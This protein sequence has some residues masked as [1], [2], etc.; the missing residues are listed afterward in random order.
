MIEP[1]KASGPVTRMP[2]RLTPVA[3]GP[4]TMPLESVVGWTVSSAC[5]VLELVTEPVCPPS[6]RTSVTLSLFWNWMMPALFRLLLLSMVTA[7]PDAGLIEPPV[8]TVTSWAV[9]VTSGAVV[10]V[11][12]LVVFAWAIAWPAQISAVRLT[13]TRRSWVQRRLS[14]RLLPALGEKYPVI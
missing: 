2:N 6:S 13:P 3:N 9:E 14:T 4:C 5:R 12:T 10:S 8:A 11:V 7:T 1:V